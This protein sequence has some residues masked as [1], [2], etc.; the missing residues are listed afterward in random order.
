MKKFVI[1]FAVTAVCIAAILLVGFT[2]EAAPVEVEL[3]PLSE[4]TVEL[5]VSCDGVVQAANSHDIYTEY[6]CVA[7]RVLV[8]TGDRVRKGETLF[9]VDADSTRRLLYASGKLGS[10]QIEEAAQQ[11][12]TAPANGV[13]TAV[14]L[15]DGGVADS[16]KPCFSISGTD[17]LQVTVA[18]AEKDLC[19]VRVGQTARV[20]GSGFSREVYGGTVTKISSVAR[21]SGGKTVVDAVVTLFPDEQDASLRIGLSAD[22]ELITQQLEHCL[23]VPYELIME[24]DSFQEY[25]YVLEQGCAVKRIVA[26]G[27]ALP[28]GLLITGGLTASDELI[29]DPQDIPESGT[30]VTVKT[31]A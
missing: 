20:S 8:R 31:E 4:R 19:S 12:I 27:E 14:G 24:D 22:V 2:T 10:S 28:D 26:T 16:S 17:A 18:V 7:D 13:V 3:F 5:S 25:V 11:V 21:S 1:L 29:G 15:T 30:P 6:T 9:T 23:V